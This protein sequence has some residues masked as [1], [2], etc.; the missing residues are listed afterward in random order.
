MF[1]FLSCML[2]KSAF[3]LFTQY[4]PH[5]YFLRRKNHRL[6]LTGLTQFIFVSVQSRSSFIFEKLSKFSA[7]VF[8]DCPDW[9]SYRWK[10]QHPPKLLW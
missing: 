2:S 1:L 5:V 7:E 9:R 8:Q 4:L 10:N 6:S 3:K